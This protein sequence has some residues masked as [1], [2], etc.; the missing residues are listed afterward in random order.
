MSHFC[1]SMMKLL[2]ASYELDVM[3]ISGPGGQAAQGLPHSGYVNFISIHMEEHLA[4][5]VG[6]PNGLCLDRIT[7]T[8]K[9][10]TSMLRWRVEP[11]IPILEV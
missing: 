1:K 10:P 8:Q 11:T 5:Q 2:L 4:R 9:T 6:T 7:Q 3:A